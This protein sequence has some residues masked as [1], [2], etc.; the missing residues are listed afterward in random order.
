VKYSQARVEVMRARI[1]EKIHATSERIGRPFRGGDF[2]GRRWVPGSPHP[3]LMKKYFGSVRAAVAAAGFP[4][5]WPGA[6]RHKRPERPKKVIPTKD[7]NALPRLT[8][9]KVSI[10][11]HLEAGAGC[12]NIAQTFGICERAV[13][14][15]IARMAK[16]LPGRGAPLNKV[17]LYCDRL[18]VANA[19]IVAEIRRAA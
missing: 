15:Q 2:T 9:R 19:D 17:M 10:L 5:D 11:L 14:D 4:S 13:Y 6:G 7:P 3:Q 12:K 18:L 1:I 8:P 16:D